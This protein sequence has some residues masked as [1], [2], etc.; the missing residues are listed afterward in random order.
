MPWWHRVR[1]HSTRS[2]CDGWFY[3][4]KFPHLHAK[5]ERNSQQKN[6]FTKYAAKATE[7]FDSNE[8][9]ANMFR[10]N[11]CYVSHIFAICAIFHAN[12]WRFFIQCQLKPFAIHYQRYFLVVIAI[13]VGNRNRL[14]APMTLTYLWF[15]TNV[16]YFVIMRRVQRYVIAIDIFVWFEKSRYIS[17]S[18]RGDGMNEGV[19]VTVHLKLYL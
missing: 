1:M 17:P 15:G 4:W 18:Q 9:N 8:Q 10:V 5:F 6:T 16:L 3:F 7:R 2:L 12:T 11:R 14:A 13:A 19:N